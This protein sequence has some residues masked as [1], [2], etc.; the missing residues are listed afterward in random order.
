MENDRFEVL[1]CKGIPFSMKVLK[2]IEGTTGLW[3]EGG[4]GL[5]FATA[6]GQA[7]SSTIWPTIGSANRLSDASEHQG[8]RGPFG[9]FC[10]T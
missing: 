6:P 5:G 10:I 9:D 7:P 3:G 8:R 1:N 2:V 4:E